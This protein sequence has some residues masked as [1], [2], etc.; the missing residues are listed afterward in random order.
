MPMQSTSLP[1]RILPVQHVLRYS[2]AGPKMVWSLPCSLLPALI[3]FLLFV[4]YPIFRSVYFSTFNWNGLGPAVKNVGIKNYIKIL[5]DEVF[6]K[7]VKNVLFIIVFSLG[8]PV[9]AGHAPGCTG[10]PRPSGPCHVPH[11]ILSPVRSL[12][13]KYRHH[14]DAAL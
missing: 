7:A 14:V 2:P 1:V 8:Y 10:G 5:S 13:S 9:A 3:L 4:I 6:L 12:R 11:N